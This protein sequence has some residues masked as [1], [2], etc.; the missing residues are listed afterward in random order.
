MIVLT[1]AQILTGRQQTLLHIPELRKIDK[2]ILLKLG[3]MIEIT[4]VMIRS[5]IQIPDHFL[6]SAPLE[7]RG[8]QEI[9]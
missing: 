9:Y 7:S 3:V 4:M 1:G 5:Q 6:L 2:Q 8:F